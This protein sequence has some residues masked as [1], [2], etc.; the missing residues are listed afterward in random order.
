[1]SSIA[2]SLLQDTSPLDDRETH[3]VL[4]RLSQNTLWAS[5]VNPCKGGVYDQRRG[6]VSWVNWRVL[7]I[8]VVDSIDLMIVV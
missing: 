7:L 5:R 6:S 4:H 1:M 8:K 2:A 3:I